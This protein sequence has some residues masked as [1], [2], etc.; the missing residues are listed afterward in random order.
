MR[1]DVLPYQGGWLDQPLWV[2]RLFNKCGLFDEYLDL[3]QKLP[4]P[5]AG[6]NFDNS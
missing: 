3:D 2:H 6:A 4:P 5:I 1:R